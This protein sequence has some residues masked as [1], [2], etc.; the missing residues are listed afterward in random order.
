MKV[1]IGAII[2]VLSFVNP[3]WAANLC[4]VT[5]VGTASTQIF[6]PIGRPMSYLLVQNVSP[7]SGGCDIY[8]ALGTANTVTVRGGT[9]LTPHGAAWLPQPPVPSTDLACIADGCTAPVEACWW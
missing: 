3:V 7:A 6:T 8:C 5:S 1:V 4:T 9:L 2:V